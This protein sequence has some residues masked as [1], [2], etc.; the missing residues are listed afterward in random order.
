MPLTIPTLDDRNYQELLDSALARIPV[1]TPEWTNFNRSDPGVTLI[2]VF[3]FLTESL[4]YRSNQIPERNRRKFLSLLGVPLLPAASARGLV[5]FASAVTD[6]AGDPMT[7]TMNRGLEVRAG[8]TPFQIEHGLDVLP[9]EAAAYVKRNLDQN[10]PRWDK[11]REYYKLLYR[12]HLD[13]KNPDAAKLQLYETA[14]LE[15]RGDSGGVDLSETV[16]GSLWI[17]LMVRVADKP[18][19]AKLAAAR[20]AIAGKTLSLGIVPIVTDDQRTLLPGRRTSVN[21][22]G[23]LKFQLPDV[24]LDGSLPTSRIPKYKTLQTSSTT[25]VL[26][27]P[28]IVQVT[29][30]AAGDLVLWNNLDP[31]E[32]GVKD[33]PPALDDT[34]KADRVIT[35]LRLRAAGG[36]Q[37]K[38]LWVGINAA[39]VSQRAHIANEVLGE[40]TG[41]P[42]QTFRL[43][44]AP[45]LPGSVRLTVTP[46]GVDVGPAEPWEAVDDLLSAGP[47]VVA[48]HGRQPPGRKTSVSLRVNAFVLDPESGV[49]RFGDGLRGRRPPFGA[50]VRADYDYGLGRLGNVGAGMIQAG[51]AL[52]PGVT[53]RNP[54]RT[55]GGADAETVLDGEKQIARHLQHR[56]RLVTVEDFDAIT[57][58]TP[59]VDVGRVE[60]LPAYHPDLSQAPDDPAGAGSVTLMLIPAYDPLHPNAPQP[61]R[62]FLNAVCAHL[63]PRRLVTT[64]VFLRGPD[65]Q[66]VWVSIGIRVVAG[67]SAAQA[68][69]G[70]RAALNDFFSPFNWPLNKLVVDREVMAVANRVAGV[71][72]VT[73]VQLAQGNGPAVAQVTLRRL[74]L[75]QVM[76]LSIVDGDPLDVDQLRSSGDPVPEGEDAFVPV[77]LIPEECR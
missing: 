37:A 50:M 51:P 74:Q 43:S 62:L 77:P 32:A 46:T 56:D 68:R 6:Q 69:E 19:P 26:L 71:Q 60:V 8:K 42:D 34:N 65:Y 70:V 21:E 67:Y 1:H 44:R 24:P 15:T 57:R 9:I 52:P 66:P 3:A 35:W 23:L 49:I 39:T 73:G 11:E 59:G 33:L 75:P 72:L 4:L 17:A 16:D 76:A 54:V 10:D 47:E 28:G 22:G 20:N 53:V 14:P 12:S 45:V 31:L 2:E 38:L 25:N 27:E 41:E 13:R 58:R 48:P 55:W 36:A 29:L 61:D 40:G 63:D 7:L 30:P 5:A 18:Y 64:Q